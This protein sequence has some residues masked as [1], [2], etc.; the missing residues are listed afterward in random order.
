MEGR[1]ASPRAMPDAQRE[2][3]SASIIAMCSRCALVK[4]FRK[5][6]GSRDVARRE[7]RLA[8]ADRVRSGF[9]RRGDL[10][11]VAQV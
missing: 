2:R 4:R 3:R 8:R 11:S 1:Q 5:R 9:S 6:M 7:A 10:G